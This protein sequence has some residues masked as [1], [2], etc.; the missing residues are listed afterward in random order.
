MEK[1]GTLKYI[2]RTSRCIGESQKNMTKD[3]FDTLKNSTMFYM[4]LGSKELFHSNFLHWISIINWDA[5]L[6]IIHDLAGVNKFWWENQRDFNGNT[7]CPSNNNLEVRR[8]Y[9]NFD[10]SIYI[11]DSESDP[12][13]GITNDDSTDEI[14]HAENGN[15]IQKWIPVLILENKMKSLPHKAQ[16]DK[17]V[18]KAY[19]DYFVG[20]AKK[21]LI[22]N[23]IK[24]VNHELNICTA[25]C[26]ITFILLSLMEPSLSNYTYKYNKTGKSPKYSITYEGEWKHKKYRDLIGKINSISSCSFSRLNYDLIKDYCSFVEALCDL[27]DKDWKIVV[28]DKYIDTICKGGTDESKLRIH[29]IREKIYYEQLLES[30]ENKL[31]IATISFKRFD[32]DDL[33]KSRNPGIVLTNISFFHSIGLFEVQYIVDDEWRLVI[34]VQGNRYCHM[35]VDDKKDI[36]D[37]NSKNPI[38][39]YLLPNYGEFIKNP[40]TVTTPYWPNNIGVPDYKKYGRYNYDNI[41]QWSE[42][43]TNST[44]ED[45]ITAMVE[46]TKKCIKL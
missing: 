18:E 32:K 6:N 46:D 21:H 4:S 44:I 15:R 37:R 10:L 33:N 31:T 29:D 27:A 35:I 5:F 45:V 2:I 26:P 1:R 7:F 30:L 8:E 40:S 3:V 22:S 20:N 17:Y 28:N 23:V 38:F 9:R 34:Q 12:A 19:K 43:P 36:I 41:Y 16:L 24:E 42:I 25:D 13:N 14:V 39:T 11:L